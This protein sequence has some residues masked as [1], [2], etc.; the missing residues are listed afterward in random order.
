[1]LAS[2]ALDHP[3]VTPPPLPSFL[4]ST[5]LAVADV[6]DVI[7]SLQREMAFYLPVAPR[8]NPEGIMSSFPLHAVPPFSNAPSL[9]SF[10]RATPILQ[11][12]MRW[13]S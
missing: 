10:L 12:R 2:F 8:R 3:S 13:M 5:H 9:A 4:R 1:M 11:W 7:N 6:T